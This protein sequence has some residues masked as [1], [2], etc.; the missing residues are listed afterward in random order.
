MEIN[1][2]NYLGK[3]FTGHDFAVSH[4]IVQTIARNIMLQMDGFDSVIMPI[5]SQK[6]PLL[7]KIIPSRAAEIRNSIIINLNLGW[8]FQ[9]E[10]LRNKILNRLIPQS[11]WYAPDAL[12]QN[13]TGQP[14]ISVPSY[15]TEDGLPLG[16]QFVGRY[17]EENNLIDIASQIEEASPWMN[18]LPN[19]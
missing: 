16:V 13:I 7:G 10:T 19:F 3:K 11:L 12:L 14:A 18:R 4:Q 9:I 15:W 6:P 1:V 5:I 17:G 8:I 2:N